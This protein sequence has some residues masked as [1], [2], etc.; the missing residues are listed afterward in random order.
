VITIEVRHDGLGRF[1]RV[2]APGRQLAEQRAAALEG[3]WE[4]QWQRRQAAMRRPGA[5]EALKKLEAEEATAE[6]ER[7]AG[8]LTSILLAALRQPAVT[9]LAPLY[10][11]AVFAEPPPAEPAAPKQEPEPRQSQ[12]KGT[13]LTLVTLLNPAAMRRR[14]ETVQTKFKT[15]HD[16]W[17]YL[18][19]WREGE[20]DKAVTAYQALRRD[21]EKRRSMFHE[22]QARANS[23]LDA[24]RQAGGDSEM[25]VGHCDLALMA[26]ERPEG[27]PRFW[28]IGFAQGTLTIDYD[29]PSMEQVPLI[30]CV[31]YAA[32]RQAFETVLLADGERERL[33]GEAVFQTSL[34]VLH[35]LFAC[36][37][38]EAIKAIVF[39]GW[40][41][42]IDGARPGRA[43]ILAVTADK[44][45]FAAFD[46][47]G[48]DPRA[49]F[50]AL[51]G[52]MSPKLAA[53]AACRAA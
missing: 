22:K 20:Y 4:E 21:W 39:N 37:A 35:T 50:C 19:R 42:Y 41:N 38:A 27:F 43:C 31:K 6:A 47:S 51:N 46:L 18:A 25:V 40:T 11:N 2:S 26:L 14:K 15:A 16:G 23:R 7:R 45:S 32:G 28:N 52:S 10:D 36:D 13:P 12:F 24:L 5:A 34:A 44:R 49:C 48:S 9:D 17:Q 3:L 53:L 33:Y 29:L 8:A 1:Q 30:K